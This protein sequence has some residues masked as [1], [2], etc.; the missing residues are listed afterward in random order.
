MPDLREQLQTHFGLD[1]FRPS[2][3]GVIED[4]LRGKDVL[5]VMPTGAGKS[6]CYQLPAVVQGGLT[7]VVSP[8]ISLMEDQVQ[9]LRDEG[10]AAAFLNS[11][12][13]ASMRRETMQ[14]LREGF[15]GLLYI[16][17]ER[18]AAADF[19]ELISAVRPKLLAIDEAHCI[20]Q[21]GHD[22]RPD[23]S[24][25]GEIRRQLDSPPCIA[26]TATATEDVRNDIIRQ[27]GLREPTIVVTGFDRPNLSYQSRRAAKVKEK[28][29]D[30]I[31]LVRGEPG[32]TIIYCATRKA[33][34][35][36]TGFLSQ[37]LTDRPI[38]AYHA[39]MDP[40]ARTANQEKFMATPRGVA[41]ATNAFGMG[42]NKPDIR[43]V[44]HYNIPGTLEAYYQ[45]AGRA[46]RDGAP[47]RCVVL[48]SYQDRYT[49]E[50]FIDKMGEE[51]PGADF[52]I[53]NQRK[54]HAR[55][56][57]E[58][59]IRYAQAHH[60]RRQMILDYFGD[61]TEVIGCACDVCQPDAQ[62]PSGAIAVISDELTL[63]VRKMLSA[64]ARLHGKF[65]IGV[66]AEVLAG[67][68]NEKTQRWG[69]DQLT[70]FGLLRERSIK[71]IVAMLHRLMDAGLARQR[72][73]DGVKFRPV[74]ELTA[75]GV[76]VM[77]GEQL[78]PASLADLIPRR[79]I[80]SPSVERR[81]VVPVERED[82]L[83]GNLTPQ[84]RDRFERLRA[85][86]SQLA[87]DRDLP[88]YCICNDRTLKLIAHFAPGDV[89]SLE[90]VKGMGPHK[91]KLYGHAL[92]QAMRD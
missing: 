40:A 71:Q 8:L 84:A 75:T 72:D 53:I 74:V 11:S 88:A 6:L 42:I 38:F 67:S 34:D 64:I 1:D 18:F 19:Q 70:V 50:F 25:L 49:Q 2:Q 15:D 30:L 78:P 73:P 20:S 14:Q 12:L 37:E 65:G 10:I 58:W 92:L 29:A 44:V 16:A 87:R 48:F 85:V 59:I 69:F 79:A 7:L 45:E 56:K 21:W 77:K 68:S 35:G 82:D 60:C 9:Q 33:V 83:D 62:V 55:E 39:G 28:D 66:V 24:R 86:R 32:S 90:Q 81:R 89:A 22:F 80:S 63:L 54:A 52:R 57:L 91:V 41:V 27:L 36:V 61:E 31:E 46:G 76:A 43:L 5:C 13:S 47:S 4:V 51:N 3:R 17:P 23:Y 26:L